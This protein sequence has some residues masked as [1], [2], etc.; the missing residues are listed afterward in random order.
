MGFRTVQGSILNTNVPTDRKRLSTIHELGHLVMHVHYSGDDMDDRANEF[1]VAV[2]I[3]E[4]DTQSELRN[5]ALANC[6]W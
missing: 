5:L 3:P 1:A 6:F 4:A 2:L